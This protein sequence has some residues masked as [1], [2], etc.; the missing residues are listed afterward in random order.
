MSRYRELKIDN[1]YTK[2]EKEFYQTFPYHKALTKY[3][4]TFNKYQGEDPDWVAENA[5]DP[6]YQRLSDTFQ[7]IKEF[8]GE[9]L[10]RIKK[11]GCIPRRSECYFMRHGQTIIRIITKNQNDKSFRTRGVVLQQMRDYL[12]DLPY[13]IQ[14]TKGWDSRIYTYS[15][16]IG[17]YIIDQIKNNPNLDIILNI[18]SIEIYKTEQGRRLIDDK[19]PIRSEIYHRIRVYLKF[20]P[21]NTHF[22]GLTAEINYTNQQK[23]F[24][25]RP[26]D[27]KLT[28]K[29]EERYDQ[30]QQPQIHPLENLLFGEKLKLN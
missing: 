22:C 16:H 6:Q 15:F 27:P 8:I 18:N 5:C 24:I 9:N 17:E 25:Y 13:F 14:D 1:S 23:N 7:T 29:W 21:S 19:I 4:Y 12:N 26:Y 28:F 2:K 11:I 3:D 10:P 20:Q 30:C